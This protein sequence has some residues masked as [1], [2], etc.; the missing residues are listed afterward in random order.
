VS[1]L[2]CSEQFNYLLSLL[3]L[4]R[5]NVLSQI[6]THP[7]FSRLTQ[8]FL[9]VGISIFDLISAIETYENEDTKYLFM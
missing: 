5:I 3:L 9:L 6:T 4:V 1:Q 2:I 7:I 8:L